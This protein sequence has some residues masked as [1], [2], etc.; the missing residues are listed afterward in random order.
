MCIHTGKNLLLG[1]QIL[2]FMGW[3]SLRWVTKRKRVAFPENVPIYL[4]IQ[5]HMIDRYNGHL[6]QGN[7][8]RRKSK[9]ILY[10][11]PKANGVKPHRKHI[12]KNPQASKV[13]VA[14]LSIF[15]A[16]LNMNTKSDMQKR[17]LNA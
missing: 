15:I 16:D 12:V 5:L 10:K 7:K 14:L 4:K 13:N 6:P 17:V 1:E 3:P 8:G 2:S 11:R 9:Y